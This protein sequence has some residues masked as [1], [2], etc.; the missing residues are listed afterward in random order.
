MLGVVHVLPRLGLGGCCSVVTDLDS[1]RLMA[2]VPTPRGRN[3]QLRL[4]RRMEMRM[5]RLR[6]FLM[7]SGW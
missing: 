6:S 3:E 2:L 4:R 1:L 7:M 5:V